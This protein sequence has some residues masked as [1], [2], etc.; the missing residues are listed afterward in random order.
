MLYVVLG[1][2]YE[3]IKKDKD[4]LVQGLEVVAVS[5][6]NIDYSMIDGYLSSGGLFNETKAIVI[7]TCFLDDE[8]HAF[9]KERLSDMQTS[10]HVFIILEPKLLKKERTLLE[11]YA[12]RITEYTSSEIKKDAG[13]FILADMFAKKDKKNLWLQFRRAVEQGKQ[14]EEIHGI[15]WW[16][17]KTMI[18]IKQSSKN[19]GLHPFVFE[20][21][22]KASEK[23]TLAELRNYA[24]KLFMIYH[25]ARSGEVD[26]EHALEKCLLE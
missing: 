5:R 13:L 2:N 16:Q 25:Q 14:I 18:L 9:F 22:K 20:K 17:I 26:F 10:D 11:K 21:N 12:A 7:D 24:Q 8:H 3:Q 23:F 15:L 19:P 6:E 4:S 1:D